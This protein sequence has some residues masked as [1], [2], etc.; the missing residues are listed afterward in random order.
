MNE[1][2]GRRDHTTPPMR[3]FFKMT[4]R[5][6]R[7]HGLLVVGTMGTVFA[8]ALDPALRPYLF[9]SVIDD[10]V[11]GGSTDVLLSVGLA[12][13][14]I[15]LFHW[16]VSMARS[17]LAAL[18]SRRFR[19]QAAPRMFD[20]LQRASVDTVRGVDSDHVSRLMTDLETVDQGMTALLVQGPV[21]LVTGALC[22]AVMAAVEWRLT[23]VGTGALLLVFVL[24][25]TVEGA[26]LKARRAW[27]LSGMDALR[28]AVEEFRANTIVRAFGLEED[29]VARY[30]SRLAH[31]MDRFIRFRA[32]ESVLATSAERAGVLVLITV[33]GTGA[34]F[35]ITDSLSVGTLYMFMTHFRRVIRFS[36]ELT[37][38]GA[39]L[40]AA[41]NSAVLVERAQHL[42]QGLTEA[43]EAVSLP[44]RAPSIECRDVSFTHGDAVGPSSVD[45]AQ[46]PVHLKHISVSIPAGAIVA[47]VGASGS[48]KTTFLQLLARF[49][50]P[51]TGSVIIDG[52]DLRTVSLASFRERLAVVPQDAFMFDTTVGDNL[53][54][55]RPDVPKEVVDAAVRM[56][57]LAEFIDS[58]PHGYETRVR[59]GGNRFSQGQRQRIAIARALIHGG[60]LLILDEATSALDPQSHADITASL[61]ARR[62]RQTVI[63][64]THRMSAAAGADLI[65]VLREGRLV[66][67]GTH[68]ELM[69][70]RGE[71]ARLV[72][73]EQE[74]LLPPTDA[75]RVERDALQTVPLFQELGDDVR[76]LLAS[77]LTSET[78]AAG[79]TIIRE[80]DPGDKLYILIKGV[81]DVARELDGRTVH[82][83][84]LPSGSYFG[85]M[86]LI[87]DVART[88]S[89]IACTDVHV[90]G[91]QQSD[92]NRLLYLAPHLRDAIERVIAERDEAN[93]AM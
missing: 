74:P 41:A 88:A 22:L 34:Y 45:A 65:L 67:H 48:G 92:F 38:L 81:V 51:S 33:L 25:R 32:L 4:G 23:L 76:E 53:T 11:V 13:V 2:N 47:V 28:T 66:E 82:V 27:R 8:S 84:S 70:Q 68:A 93:A 29:A 52:H 21:A 7:S 35:A 59:D 73:Q 63:Y 85:E 91:L 20:R 86:A 26:F 36:Q 69:A 16:L 71:Y 10:A 1:T 44:D 55:S 43:P 90:Y 77:R 60:R 78:Y 57:G 5:H 50:D 30:R 6:V 17:Y 14:G 46:S 89:V 40:R 9:R 3:T 75:A 87:K 31:S 24:P 64:T 58:L 18:L 62:G 83:A 80:G 15:F 12:V 39:P 54:R 72:V 19:E 42:P 61:H 79:E 37:S 56:V 49:F